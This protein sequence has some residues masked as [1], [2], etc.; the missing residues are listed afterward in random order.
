MSSFYFWFHLLFLGSN[1]NKC[2]PGWWS[3]A[4]LPTWPWPSM[5][6][7]CRKVFSECSVSSAEARRP[8]RAALG[9]AN[10]VTDVVSTFNLHKCPTWVCVNISLRTTE[11]HGITLI[12]KF[13]VEFGISFSER[14]KWIFGTNQSWKRVQMQVFDVSEP[15]GAF[16]VPHSNW[17]ML[18]WILIT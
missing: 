18:Y 7:A 5:M 17:D 10:G 14:P 12:L 15:V 6:H 1:S 13:L 3:F 11:S 8:G 4:D 16:T 9:V 2:K